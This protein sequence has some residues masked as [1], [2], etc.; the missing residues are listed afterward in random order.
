VRRQGHKVAWAHLVHLNPL[1]SNLGDVL[2]RH[3]KVLV[4]ELNLGQLCKVVRAEY[5]VDAQSLTKVQGVPFTALEV[6]TAILAELGAEAPAPG[7][8]GA[9][10]D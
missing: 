5:L 7:T 1:P 10:Y 2:G 4:P 9:S 3:G 8:N 6:E